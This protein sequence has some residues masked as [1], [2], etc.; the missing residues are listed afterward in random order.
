MNLK[1]IL[2]KLRNHIFFG[3]Y[4]FI[5]EDSYIVK[6]MRII[7][8]KNIFIGNGCS[9]LNGA[10]METISHWENQSYN[11][12]IVIGDNCSIEQCCH[13]IA[14]NELAIGSHTVISAFVYIADCGHSYAFSEESIMQNPLEVKKTKIGKNCF[15]GIGAKIMP[16]VSLGDHVVVGANAVVTKN[17]P[18]N[19]MVAGIP[20]RIIKKYD[21]AKKSWVESV[22]SKDEL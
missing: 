10:R 3:N 18:P 12:K 17:V 16:G 21:T 19:T 8:K 22:V 14:A 4:G 2:L 5:G 20:A 6:P 1:R 13:I 11:G 7:G 9:I 15:I